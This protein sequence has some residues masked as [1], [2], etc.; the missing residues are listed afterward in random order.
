MKIAFARLFRLSSIDLPV[1]NGDVWRILNALN[2]TCYGGWHHHSV[3][4]AF[5]F[6]TI[7]VRNTH[8]AHRDFEFTLDH[9]FET[10]ECDV[11]LEAHKHVQVLLRAF[12]KLISAGTWDIA[13]IIRENFQVER[14]VA[15]GIERRGRWGATGDVICLLRVVSIGE[16]AGAIA[17]GL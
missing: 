10:L 8:P 2:I 15:I 16:R 13:L 5:D 1:L 7:S 12:N 17:T 11:L 14:R 6:V 3:F 4:I 9:S